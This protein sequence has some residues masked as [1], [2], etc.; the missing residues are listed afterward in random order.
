MSAGTTQVPGGRA[1]ALADELDDALADALT[2]ALADALALGKLDGG[3]EGIANRMPDRTVNVLLAVA[4]MSPTMSLMIGVSG[5]NT[6]V[7]DDVAS[8]PISFP[9]LENV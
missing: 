8:D 3:A 5:R 6:Q 4:R 9:G 7:N 2:D 1:D